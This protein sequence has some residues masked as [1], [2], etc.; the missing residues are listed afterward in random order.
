MG[1]VRNETHV[2]EPNE[3]KRRVPNSVDRTVKSKEVGRVDLRANRVVSEEELGEVGPGRD[4]GD[5]VEGCIV[6]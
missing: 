1:D 5:G 4:V 6:A 2:Q 3:P